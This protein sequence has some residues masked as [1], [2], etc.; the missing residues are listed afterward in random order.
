MIETV[1]A[2]EHAAAP[3]LEVPLDPKNYISILV[4]IC[5][6][7]GL[8]HPQMIS[9]RTRVE[10]TFHAQPQVFSKRAPAPVTLNGVAITY[11]LLIGFGGFKDALKASADRVVKLARGYDP[12]GDLDKDVQKAMHKRAQANRRGR[13]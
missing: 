6:T 8:S 11:G 7:F 1:H 9:L 2:L 10:K 13:R 5:N 12:Y 3:K 4:S